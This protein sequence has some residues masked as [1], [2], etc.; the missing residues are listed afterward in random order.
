VKADLHIH[1]IF[2]HDSIAKPES[3]LAAAVD[4]GI[5]II[6]ITDHETTR[7]WKS[8]HELSGKYNVIVIP[9]QEVKVYNSKNEVDG[10]L[11][12][13]FLQ[14]PI[15]SRTVPEIIEEVKAQGGLVSIAH[16][17]SE[18]RCEFRGY[19]DISDW[20]SIGVEVMN[21]R[22]YNRRDDEMAQAMAD[23]LKTFITAGSDAHTPFE[24]G[25]VFLEFDGSTAEDLKTAIL[26]RD[27]QVAGHS[28]NPLFSLI[29][30]FGRIGL[31]L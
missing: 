4:R 10:E 1:S 26:N 28:S 7:G 8:F 17:F 22:T 15:T 30:S 5:G 11:L 12:C 9:G 16:P 14:K 23:R 31:A 20:K 21:G 18:R 27:V 19:M 3:I 25:H 29:S 2:S 13:L 6:S 24:V